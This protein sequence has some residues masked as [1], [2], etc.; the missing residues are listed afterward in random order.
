MYQGIET[1]VWIFMNNILGSI[2]P[3]KHLKYIQILATELLALTKAQTT[4]ERFDPQ[5]LDTLL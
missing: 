3:S 2:P 4:H 5:S 1:P